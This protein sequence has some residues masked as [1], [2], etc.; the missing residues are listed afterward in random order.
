MRI[1]VNMVDTN[2]T[3]TMHA[4]EYYLC[5][6]SST[7]N[8]ACAIVQK[9]QDDSFKLIAQNDHACARQANVEL[10][11]SVNATLAEAQCSYS[12]LAGIIVGRG[13]GSFTGVRIGVACAKG[14]ACGA[15]LPLLGV[16][17]LDAVAFASWEAGV[18]GDIY[19]VQD[20]MR[21][22]VYPAQYCLS[23]E[24]VVRISGAEHVCKVDAC[25]EE[26]HQAHKDFYVVGNALKK[27]Q[28]VFVEAGFT[29][30]DN[31]NIYTVTGKSLAYAYEFAQMQTGDPAL[32]LPIYTRLSDAEEHER[33]KLG[34]PV[35]KTVQT[36]GCEEVLAGRH[37]QYRPLSLN[38]CEQVATLEE[39]AHKNTHHAPW[40][41][42]LFQEELEQ[43]GHIWWVAHDEE[44]I[45]G[46]A[47][48]CLIDD[49]IE[50]YDVCVDEAYRRQGIARTLLERVTY[51]A[52]MF[53]KTRVLLEVEDD[54][55]AAQALYTSIGFTQDGVRK[56]Y[57]GAH[58]DA[59]LFSAHLPLVC[60]TQEDLPRPQASRQEIQ[61]PC[62]HAPEVQ[63]R[64]DEAG[65]LIL[66][67][68]SSCDETAMAI[69]DEH[70]NI[71]ANVV[72]TQIDFHARFGGVVPEI[73]SRKHTEAI[74]GV[75]EQVMEQAGAYFGDLHLNP[76]DLYAVAV[77]QGPGLVGALVIGIAFAKGLAAAAHTKLIG[78]NHLEG[79]LFA[80][81]F[82]TP[83][84]EPP[85]IASLIS[86]GHTML[87][88]VKDWGSYEVLGQTLDDAVGEA[89]DKVAKALGLGYPGGPIISRLAEKGNPKAITFPRA[90]LHSK[91]YAFSLSGLK[92]AVITY[93]NQENQAGRPINLPDLAASFEAA[94]IEVQVKKALRAQEETGVS[95]FCVGGGVA[96]NPQLRQA[97]E[98]A[99]AKRAVRVTEPPL[100]ACTD[101]A[102]MIA[103]VAYY[104]L[105]K[106]NLSDFR[107]DAD[108]NMSL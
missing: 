61:Q 88:H 27:Y 30:C 95:D 9:N 12:D 36:T 15:H 65:K 59:Y 62:Q 75:Y 108:P 91:D 98:K 45:V 89:F 84:L 94:V 70:K 57:Y 93:I 26:I 8:L 100:G 34:R 73:A 90:M 40:S 96:A 64:I 42:K 21:H 55:K 19:V 68:E 86:G 72:S 49:A 4:G 18:R 38:D 51:D 82:E 71:I 107:M 52:Q 74:V 79:H 60:D 3:Y 69:I 87:V 10:V 58:H 22:E 67:I 7:D 104:Q 31:S 37:L 6:D 85:F 20:A 5:I 14:I 1:D 25:I 80:N 50:I 46:F 23:D 35:P 2:T 17:V 48:G 41:A 92:T 29:C 28:D 77:T 99:F 32:V 83:D 44:K 105:E 16:S 76:E 56:D 106:N 81:L 39:K 63:K 47:G 103:R 102:A 13:P 11:E 53:G 101:N 78:V 33:I 54:N 43:T 24:G 97:Y 66:A